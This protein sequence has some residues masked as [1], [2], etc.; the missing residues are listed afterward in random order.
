MDNTYLILV[1]LL[2]YRDILGQKL[3]RLFK[4]DR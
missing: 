1:T 2:I 4:T 3:E